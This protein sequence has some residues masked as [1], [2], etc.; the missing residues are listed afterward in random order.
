MSQTEFPE[1][2]K[3]GNCKSK[4]KTNPDV[5]DVTIIDPQPEETKY[6]WTIF[7]EID[8]NEYRLPLRAKTENKKLYRLY[9][10]MLHKG[11]VKPRSK[12]TIKTWMSKSS[13]NPDRDLR[14]FRISS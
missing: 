14:E 9:L 11:K 6:D 13:K 7:C 1:F 12:I 3:W 2:F 5:I 8:G 4:D 10:M